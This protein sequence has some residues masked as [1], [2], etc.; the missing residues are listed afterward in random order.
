MDTATSQTE[1]W[2]LG[3]ETGRELVGGK[4]DDSLWIMKWRV[5]LKTWGRGQSKSVCCNSNYFTMLNHIRMND[6]GGA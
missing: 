5:F 3:W 6:K 1:I 4:I 2:E